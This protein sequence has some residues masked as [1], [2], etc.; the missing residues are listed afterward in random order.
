MPSNL[1]SLKRTMLRAAT[2][3]KFFIPVGIGIPCDRLGGHRRMFLVDFAVDDEKRSGPAIQAVMLFQSGVE[4]VRIATN[5]GF[6]DQRAGTSLRR[7]SE[8][9]AADDR[10][11]VRDTLVDHDLLLKVFVLQSNGFAES[12][13]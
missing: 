13:H 5:H 12:F 2:R 7:T 8:K 3:T 6:V 4:L 10:P 9:H 11:R 1:A